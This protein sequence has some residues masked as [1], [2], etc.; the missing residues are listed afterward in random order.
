MRSRRPGLRR[1]EKQFRVW[2]R[3]REGRRIP[4]ELWDAA[5]ALLAEHS[6][7]EICRAL[8]LNATRFKEAREA[9]RYSGE[10]RRK[11]VRRSGA[12][13]TPGAL[14]TSRE[15]A[16]RP[17]GAFVELPHLAEHPSGLRFGAAPALRAQACRLTIEGPTGTLT[18]SLPAIEGELAELVRRCIFTVLGERSAA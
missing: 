8:G 4:S 10:D 9:R 11:G 16:G 12:D 2:R 5:V 1:V 7:S 6:S 13:R 14:R 17:L 3:R 15:R 18:I